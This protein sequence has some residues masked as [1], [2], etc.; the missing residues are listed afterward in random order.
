MEASSSASRRGGTAERRYWAWFPPAEGDQPIFPIRT[1]FAQ[2]YAPS[3]LPSQGFAESRCVLNVCWSGACTRSDRWR[4]M[5]SPKGAT[6]HSPGQRPGS[7][8]HFHLQCQAL[9][10][11]PELGPPLQGWKGKTNRSP[12]PLAWAVLGRPF[13]APRGLGSS[14]T[15]IGHYPKSGS[16]LVWP[17]GANLAV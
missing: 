17:A 7:Q 12:R 2:H 8:G 11:R 1:T 15:H 9:K 6:Y 3:S 5:L 13:G 4:A 16:V 14:N 10:G